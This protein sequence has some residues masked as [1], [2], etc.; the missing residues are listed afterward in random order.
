MALIKS[1]R[2]VVKKLV[3]LQ[4]KTEEDHG[5]HAT[6]QE[7]LA[8]GAP[9]FDRLDYRRE[10]NQ[11]RVFWDVSESALD[12]ARCVL[13]EPGS[14]TLR[15]V[16]IST[17]EKGSTQ[18]ETTDYEQIPLHG[19]TVVS[20]PMNPGQTVLLSLG[21]RAPKRFVSI[22]HLREATELE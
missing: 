5:H 22:M 21:L 12:R 1:A 3:Q 17:D 20:S 6:K 8:K 11:L 7:V 2:Q 4:H 18:S 10:S 16:T 13:L 14:L 15:I 9:Q 19:S